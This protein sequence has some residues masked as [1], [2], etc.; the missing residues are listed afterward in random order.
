MRKG[1]KEE[2]EASLLKNVPST[3][4]FIKRN[5]DENI[6]VVNINNVVEENVQQ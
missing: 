2:R 6:V 5:Q 3:A 4:F 1:Q